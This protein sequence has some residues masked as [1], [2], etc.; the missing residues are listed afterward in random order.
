M[1]LKN[2]INKKQVKSKPFNK[3]VPTW[4]KLKT[5]GFHLDL[6]RQNQTNESTQ[7][8][9]LITNKLNPLLTI[10]TDNSLKP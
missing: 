6:P 3:Y 4:K 5:C 1:S 10:P 7:S 9:S 2:H 8:Y